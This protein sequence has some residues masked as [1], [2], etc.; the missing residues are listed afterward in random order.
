[1][2]QVPAGP[3]AALAFAID[4]HLNQALTEA[5]VP[6][7]SLA[8]DAEFLRRVYLDIT[9]RIPSYDATVAFLASQ[10][11]FKRSKLIDD[12]LASPDYGRHFAHLWTDI[13]VKRDFDNNKNL[14]TEAFTA[15][16]ADRFNKD[17]GWNKIVSD[18][19]TA[20]GKEED[21]PQTFFILANQDNNQ[22]APDKLVGTTGNLFM[23]IQLQCAQC[24]VHPFTSQWKQQDFWGMAAFYGH[25]KA[26]REGQGKGNKKGGPATIKEVD[27]QK[28]MQGKGAKDKD[29]KPVPA[30]ASIAI[31]DPN[32]PKK[33]TGTARAKFFEG[34]APALAGR[35]PY[36]PALAAWLTSEKNHYFAPATV[37]R[38]WAHFF[39]RGFVNPIE[40]MH[41]KNKPS[42]PALLQH[43]STELG[44][45][46]YDLKYLIRAICNSQA[47]QRT[48]R[49]VS[50]NAS[51]DR[52]FSHMAVKVLGARELLDSLAQATS[53]KEP[54]R[55]NPNGAVKGGGP[56][57]TGGNPM[58][59][60]F[61]T[62]EY[63][64]DPTEYSYG[65]PQVLRL[66]N[67]NLSASSAEAAN[68]LAR[69][70]S[71][72]RGKIIEDIFLTILSRKPHPF[73]VQRMGD[74]VAKQGDSKGY[75]GVFWAL[76]NSAEFTSNH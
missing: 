12:L 40:D 42:H 60:F 65:I 36:R 27:V 3:P 8:G 54:N 14:K 5:G 62:R 49:P 48:S 38:L 37:N 31:P 59:R 16:L 28:P 52:L 29:V 43:L 44:R 55:A 34:P 51:D 33:T 4:Q 24:H 6:A 25:T 41:D 46:G 71:G 47:Y 63:E 53:H 20:E 72:N 57:G 11:P 17:T 18:L 70:G 64:D 10:D 1:M 9:G 21:V 73:E 74:F 26:E 69:A 76:L 75:A 22:P 30:G 13:L 67:S 50:A 7:S 66:M 32:D 19:V 61:D 39:A 56:T 2:P 45:G 35:A 23:G 58:V 15:W 68:R